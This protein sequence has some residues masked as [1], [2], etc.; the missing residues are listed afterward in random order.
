M[1]ISWTDPAALWLL[2]LVPLVWA[3]HWVARTNFN[4]RQRLVQG[5]VR[6][7]L[8]AAIACA[9][10]RPVIATSSSRASIVYVVDVS[11]SVSSR[12]VQD[13]AA[14]ID[15]LNGAIQPAH[16]RI[17]AFGLTAAVLDNTK[18]LRDLAEVAPE[19]NPRDAVN[20]TGTDLEA[21]IDVARA[22]LAP[23]Y[24]PRLILSQRR[25]ANRRRRERRRRATGR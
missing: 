3:A 21:A 4:G 5:A 1:S 14:R 11:H 2:V 13:A 12:A 8:L 17:V 18:A 22:E 9:L 19:P 25:D 24:V 10:A 7:L 16:F 23:G 20:R 6:S 15:E